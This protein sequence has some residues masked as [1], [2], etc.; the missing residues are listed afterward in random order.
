MTYRTDRQTEIFPTLHTT[1]GLA[2]ARPNY[3]A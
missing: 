2:L 3:I 1:G